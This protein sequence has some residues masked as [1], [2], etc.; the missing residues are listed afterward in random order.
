[1]RAF[2][3]PVPEF[4]LTAE[5]TARAASFYA[6]WGFV[7]VRALE[8]EQCAELVREQWAE[9]IRKQ[10]WVEP[11]KVFGARGELSPDDAGYLETITAPLTARQRKEF[12]RAWPMHRG[13]GA[14]CDDANFH[15][16]GV[17]AIRQDP[18]LY[19]L[20]AKLTSNANLW[21]DVNR[22]IHKLPGEGS[23]EFLHWDAN[24]LHAEGAEGDEPA[25][26][27]GKVLYTPARAVLVPG[28]HT[29]EF[30]A[31]FKALYGAQFSSVSPKAA[32]VALS[33]DKPDPLGLAGR[34]VQIPIGAGRAVF[35]S[36][37]LLHGMAKTPLKDPTE[38]G[39]YLGY[40]AAGARA[41]YA[42]KCGVDERED[43]V[44]SYTLGR[45]PK[46]WPSFD[47]VHFAPRRFTNFPHLL[48]AYVRKMPHDH[49]SIVRG[50]RVTLKPWPV[51]GYVPPELTPLGRRLLGIS[52]EEYEAAQEAAQ[53]K[54]KRKRE[55]A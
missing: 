53:G 14:C 13:F 10:P 2:E 41:E 9:V 51:E 34:A 35:W 52:P 48:D 42:R 25:Q 55:D 19:A 31:E 17:W 12:A 39:T 44:A 27:C 32:K 29:A 54:R 28:T 11:I 26:V 47:R 30:R 33:R 1:M 7:V 46:L 18:R 21:V 40:F 23:Y 37:W 20:A 43:R 49:P 24:P 6:E 45:A 16:R 38:Y 4:E 3:G 15:L 22:S 5:G 50:A 8:A 36:K